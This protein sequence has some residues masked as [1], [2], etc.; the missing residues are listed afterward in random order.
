MKK[1]TVSTDGPTEEEMNDLYYQALFIAFKY[2]IE[3]EKRN[4]CNTELRL[5]DAIKAART[6]YKPKAYLK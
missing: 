1:I 6:L 3:E 2:F 5:V 4:H